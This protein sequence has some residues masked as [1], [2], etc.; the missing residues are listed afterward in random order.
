MRSQ[1][2]MIQHFMPLLREGGVY[3]KNVTSFVRKAQKG[4]HVVTELHGK[5]ETRRT[6]K[7]GSSWVVCARSAGEH[8]VVTD[9][10]FRE[11]YDAGS[12]RVIENTVPNAEKL[13]EEGFLEYDSKRKIWAC[14]VDESGMRFVQDQGE[15][16]PIAECSQF[17]APWDEPMRVE[18][19]DYLATTYGEE[20][21]M[22]IYRIERAAFGSTYIDCTRKVPGLTGGGAE[23]VADRNPNT[24]AIVEPEQARQ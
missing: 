21:N 19:G 7:D 5:E 20:E 16:S 17:M 4:E 10:Q 23:E 3:R 14:K 8:Y 15:T 22:E 18:L 11:S 1:A 24:S 12:G 9:R 13:H 6:V 2:E